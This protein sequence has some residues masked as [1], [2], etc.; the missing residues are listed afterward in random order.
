MNVTGADECL[1]HARGVDVELKCRPVAGKHIALEI[2]W[3][4]QSEGVKPGIEAGVDL[5]EIDQPRRQKLGR[6]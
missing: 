6:A 5:G 3:H 1:V 4:V 2:G